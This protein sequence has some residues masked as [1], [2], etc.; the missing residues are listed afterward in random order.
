MTAGHP[1]C[2]N[3][4]IGQTDCARS[5]LRQVHSLTKLNHAGGQAEES[6]SSVKNIYMVCQ[7]NYYMFWLTGLLSIPFKLRVDDLHLAVAA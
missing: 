4:G 6:V 7:K 3:Q 5:Y 1:S 2:I